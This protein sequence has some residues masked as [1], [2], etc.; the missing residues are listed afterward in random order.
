M[1]RPQSGGWSGRGAG[2]AGK[3]LEGRG[4]VVAGMGC[5]AAVKTAYISIRAP[6][7]ID[8]GSGFHDVTA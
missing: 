6:A 5:Y 2:R 1:D 3:E 7:V 4:D 8:R